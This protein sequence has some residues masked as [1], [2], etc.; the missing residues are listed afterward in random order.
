MMVLIRVMTLV[1]VVTITM[2]INAVEDDNDDYG[3]G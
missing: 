3:D 1:M 2:V